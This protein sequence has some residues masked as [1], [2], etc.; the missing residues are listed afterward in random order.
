ML[1][2]MGTD[3]QARLGGELRGLLG[4][5]LLE[6]LGER[7]HEAAEEP[8]EVLDALTPEGQVVARHAEV[9]APG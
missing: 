3:L 5:A 7:I 6:L 2:R 8:G 9:V 4:D 1:P